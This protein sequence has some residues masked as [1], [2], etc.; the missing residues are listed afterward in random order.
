MGMNEKGFILR[1]AEAIPAK[2]ND[3]VMVVDEKG[4]IQTVKSWAS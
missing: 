2:A 1:A 4:Q 3:K